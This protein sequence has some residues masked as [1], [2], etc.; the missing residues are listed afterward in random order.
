MSSIASD[1][2]D[3][4]KQLRQKVLNTLKS[5]SGILVAKPS[6]V[7]RHTYLGRDILAPNSDK[8]KHGDERGYVPV[9]WWLCS[10]VMAGNPIMK[11]NEGVA[12]FF[13]DDNETALFSDILKIAELEV[14]G[15]YKHSWPLIK[16]LDI[17]GRATQPTFNGKLAPEEVP[18][19]PCHVH[20]GYICDGR[21]CGHGKLEAYFFPPLPKGKEVVGAKTRLGIKPGTSKETLCSCMCR[22]GID[23]DMYTHLNV[24]DVEPFS[25]WTIECGVIHAPGPYLTFE[26]Q[27]PQDD[28]NLLAWQLGQKIEGEENLKEE[29]DRTM[30]KGMPDEAS[31][32]DEVVN[33]S[34]TSVENFKEKYF[35]PSKTIEEGQWGRRLQTFFNRFYGEAIELNPGEKY[36]LK[37]T[38]MPCAMVVWLGSGIINGI[39][40]D[41]QNNNA[42]EL[43]IVPDT[44]LDIVNNNSNE[45][46]L[47]LSVYPFS[48]AVEKRSGICCAGLTC[49]DYII[50]GTDVIDHSTAHVFAKS[51]HRCCGG[52]VPN[53]SKIVASF[54][55]VRCEALTLIGVD[56]DGDFILKEMEANNVGTRYVART[57]EASTQV[58]F[59][60]VYDSGERACIVIQGATALL[61][62]DS[63]IGEVGLGCKRIDMLRELLWINLGYPFELT[64]LQRSN[65]SDL[66]MEL[67]K[68]DIAISV[69]MN[70]ATSASIGPN[71]KDIVSDALPYIAVVHANIHEAIAFANDNEGLIPAHLLKLVDDGEDDF[72]KV[73][74]DDLNILS[75]AFLK[76]NVALVAITLGSSGA[77]LHMNDDINIV[78][79]QFRSALGEPTSLGNMIISCWVGESNTFERP[80]IPEGVTLKSTVGAGDA[81]L[82][83]LLVGLESLCS[84]DGFEGKISSLNSLLKFAQDVAVKHIYGL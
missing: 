27:L 23:D 9:E 64:Q 59:L 29:R 7:G 41:Y 39:D 78:R 22:F 82:A 76:H 6:L 8:E 35:H 50:E 60:P 70:G 10:T 73:T 62:K 36:S 5:N 20:N 17:G 14:L 40:V 32:F 75:N 13:M 47:L 83:G 58:S 65:L 63:I 19:I 67:A 84:G 80:I 1:V 69:D 71:V 28:G 45:K 26:V 4:K 77:F 2:A 68:I 12:K 81:F 33:M 43:L 25:G 11:D 74:I 34:L 18:P 42:R 61:N 15:K 21:C 24:Y 44:T 48:P 51:F 72:S 52:S 66:C 16:V 30:L 54:D 31:L 38:D 46:L 37:K 3:S 53:T 57:N 49:V 56:N 79:Q 55:N